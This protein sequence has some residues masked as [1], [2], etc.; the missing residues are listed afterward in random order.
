MHTM[1]LN[2]IREK[3]LSFFE[4]KGHLRLP[5]FPLVPIND[6]SLLL[7]NSG[8]APMKKYFTGEVTPPR[9]RV[10]TCQRCIR[11]PDLDRVG[12][13]ARHGSYFEM[14]GNFSFGDY[15]K[16]EA[17]PWAWEFLTKVMEIPEQL[18]WPSVYESDDEAYRI[19]RDVIGIPEDRIVRLG[20]ADNFWEHGA[21]PC[22]PCSEIYFDRG[23]KYG[24][25]SPDC[26]PGCDCDRYMEIWNNVFTQFNNDGNG[27]Y[28]ELQQK[29]ID[30]GM[31]LERLACVIQSV[32]NMFEVDTV[33]RIL[34]KVCQISG[35]T[36]GVNDKD[37]ISIRIVT[38]H[39]RG[40]T[41]MICDGVIPSNEGRGYVLRRILRRAARYGKLL[42]IDRPFLTEL[43]EVVL[44]ENR[45]AYPELEEKQVYIKKVIGVEEER[46][47][48]TI[49]GGLAILSELM[50]TQAEKTDKVL[51]GDAVF[52][53]YD[54]FGFPLD[55][56]VEIAAE[57]G[58]SVEEAAF[59]ALMEKQKQRA[60]QA[61]ANISGWSEASRS[62]VESL[63]KT[64]FEGYG[65][66][67]GEGKILAL[68]VDEQP[69]EQVSEGECT[70][71]LDKTCFYAEGG[72]QVGDVG[73]L[74]GGKG[75]LRVTDTKKNNGVYLHLCTVEQG[76]ISVGELV[77]GTVDASRR[78]A[79]C[80]NHSSAHL[81]QAA[82][83][84]VLGG[85]VEQAG[86]YVDS[87]KMRF[88][89]TH[90]AAM[91]AEELTAV[92]QAVNASVLQGVAV[93]CSE[94]PLDEAKKSGAIALFG[95]KYGDTV[96]VVRMGDVSVEFCGGC[97]VENTGRI[98]L[99]HIVSESGVAAGVRRIEAVTGWN[100][101]SLLETSEQ[102]IAATAAVLK[103]NSSELLTK[104]EATVAELKSAHRQ[105]GELNLRLSAFTADELISG[106]ETM[107]E[108]L[109]V[110]ADVAGD[111]ETLRNMSDLIRQ[112]V[113]NAVVLLSCV[114]GGKIMFACACGQE[115][116]KRG[117]HAGNMVKKAAAL[118]GGGGGGRPDSAAAGGR[119]A[120]HR[121]AAVAA[122]REMLR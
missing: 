108:T 100:L 19:W 89:F 55:L 112:K 58:F 31:G 32:D 16:S 109:F 79:I 21:G 47:D 12:K 78:A 61:R 80:R 99:F 37:D 10:T 74:T 40:A 6:K 84:N 68:F 116:V 118:C 14:L 34:D 17:I 95:E 87:E 101:L 26:K 71:V 7:I 15:F 52:R 59:H 103:G 106:G 82:L 93:E 88:D 57:Q 2:E 35:K 29:N 63:M 18:L 4:S 9:N 122:V 76:T 20:K 94:M 102:T 60:R 5:S 36:Y 119:D 51:P 104:A 8:M 73:F 69:V 1:G 114:S 24:C 90:F 110:C 77:Q 27:N 98:G 33:R 97:H 120:S 39:I 11:T 86:S 23:E 50:R 75:T 111:A 13:T 117:N 43:C 66:L 91:T 22:G 115:A 44:A 81:L 83:R 25:G 96:R 70:V 65:S 72:G 45:S 62:A 64:E 48:A 107:G 30:T 105:I 56:T 42:G 54:T 92:E 49:D 41:F 3:Y 53:L 113:P 38:D 85:H 46:F 121:E 67:C 28:T